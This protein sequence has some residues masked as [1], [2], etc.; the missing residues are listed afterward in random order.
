MSTDRELDTPSLTAV[1][2]Q[3]DSQ[4]SSVITSA[5]TNSVLLATMQE[6]LKCVADL[7]KKVD[8]PQHGPDDE[9]IDESLLDDEFNEGEPAS[10]QPCLDAS[11]SQMLSSAGTN[12]STDSAQVETVETA[13][14]E[15]LSSS[16]L[17]NIAQELQMEAPCAP[18]VLDQLATIANNL[19]REKLPDDTLAS[20]YK[21]YD[22][23][24]NCTALLTVKVNPPIW[25]KLKSETRSNDLKFQKVQTALNK[26]LIAMV[27]VTDA[28]TK[29]LAAS[30]KKDL[31]STEDMIRKLT[32]AVAFVSQANHD[33]YA[34][35]RESIKPE[36]H[37]DYRPLCSPSNPVTEWLFGDDLS[38]KVK[39]MTEVNKVGQRVSHSRQ[40]DKS[41]YNAPR[42]G[43]QGQKHFFDRRRFTPPRK[44]GNSKPTPSRQ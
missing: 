42:G 15:T 20:K 41:R 40:F 34:K 6:M 11:V 13:S 4:R 35:R 8:Q 22:R 39:D 5:E 1:S 23:P 21:L 43:R 7:T 3:D 30:E 2:E 37:Q 32:D 26:S 29:S 17:D 10:K 19:A 38:K 36:L 24:E 16:I 28:L 14:P 18:R 25:D 44:R 31:P 12:A 9:P 27:Q 33:I